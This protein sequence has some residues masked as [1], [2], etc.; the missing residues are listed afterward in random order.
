MKKRLAALM[1]C[2]ALLCNSNVYASSA[3]LNMD[4]TAGTVLEETTETSETTEQV[5]SSETVEQDDK[6]SAFPELDD[7]FLTKETEAVETETVETETETETEIVI[8]EAPSTE[9]HDISTSDLHGY[10]MQSLCAEFAIDDKPWLQGGYRVIWI[11]G[12]PFY[13]Q[14]LEQSIYDQFWTWIDLGD[15][16]WGYY[17]ANHY[18]DART[19]EFDHQK[20][21]TEGEIKFYNNGY[22]DDER[23]IEFIGRYED[24]GDVYLNKYHFSEIAV[25]Q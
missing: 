23:S 24:V 14:V 8:E 22:I 9:T 18:A 17:S 19:M 21:N 11:D 12:L 20:V 2:G 5:E 13:I 25:T 10:T 1:L 16:W 4:E 15:G 3:E 6:Q 7:D